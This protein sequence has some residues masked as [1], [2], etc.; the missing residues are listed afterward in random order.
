MTGE[1]AGPPTRLPP[2]CDTPPVRHQEPMCRQGNE[3]RS[4]CLASVHANR[5][6]T[7]ALQR[8]GRQ[9]SV[10]CEEGAAHNDGAGP[11]NVQGQDV[12]RAAGDDWQASCRTSDDGYE[13]SL[14]A[15]ESPA[16]GFAPRQ[17]IWI[18]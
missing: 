10:R 15:S 5:P 6:L 1:A 17:I 8:I 18:V 14:A 16:A 12:P 4:K 11:W 9:Q 7:P 3:H 2:D 13:P